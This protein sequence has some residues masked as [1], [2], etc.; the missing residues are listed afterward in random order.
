[1]SRMSAVASWFSWTQ[2]A[3]TGIGA[4]IA[5]AVILAL[6]FSAKSP[7]RMREEVPTSVVVPTTP[8]HIGVPFP[9]KLAHSMARQRAEAR[10]GLALLVAGFAMQAAVYFFDPDAQLASSGEKLLALV[11]VVCAWLL[12]LVGMF[13]YV[14]WDERRTIDRIPDAPGL[15]VSL[16][17]SQEGRETVS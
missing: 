10:L 1:M 6:S 13:T 12:A 17:G 8:G 9:Q 14:R 5:G 2:L 4:D 16:F 7:E 15:Y 3:V 11:F